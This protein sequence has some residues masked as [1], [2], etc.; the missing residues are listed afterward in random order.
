MRIVFGVLYTLK[1][2]ESYEKWAEIQLTNGNQNKEKKL[3]Q[4]M[5]NY[6]DWNANAVQWKQS[7]M[8]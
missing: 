1:H 2:A 7:N 3:V 6:A 5:K 8:L 4:T